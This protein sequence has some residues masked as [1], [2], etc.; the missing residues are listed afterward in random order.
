MRS[1]LKSNGQPQPRAATRKGAVLEKAVRDKERQYRE[2]AQS[3]VGELVVLGC[4]VGG[5]WLDTTTDLVRL[6]AK[7]K[8]K[9]VHPLLRRSTQ[10]AWVD[11]WWCQL[12][13]AVQDALAASLLAPNG[14]N[15]VLNNAVIENVSVDEVLA[16][17]RWA[18][19]GDPRE[20]DI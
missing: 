10:L 5:R 11:R 13:T 2:V 8:V 6:L 7:H 20:E 19:G 4:E 17:Q 3:E 12:G 1:P 15:L 9:N 16:C 14:K 18:D